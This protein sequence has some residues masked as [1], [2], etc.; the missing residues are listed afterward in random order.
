MIRRTFDRRR[1]ALGQV[2]LFQ[3]SL[4]RPISVMTALAGNSNDGSFEIT[5]AFGTIDSETLRVQ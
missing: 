2:K 4:L 1:L 5:V 3:F